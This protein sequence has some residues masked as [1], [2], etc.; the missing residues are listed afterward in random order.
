MIM[1]C[2]LSPIWAGEVQ[3]LDAVAFEIITCSD[4][5][6]SVIISKKNFFPIIWSVKDELGLIAAP[7][8]F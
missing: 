3:F 5:S 1:L 7:V 6:G 4:V 2:Y 8:L